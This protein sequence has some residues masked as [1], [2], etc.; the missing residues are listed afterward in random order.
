MTKTRRWIFYEKNPVTHSVT[1]SG[2]EKHAESLRFY[3]R[4]AFRGLE[5][6]GFQHKVIPDGRICI[7]SKPI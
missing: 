4:G 2:G 3:F 5:G 7:S 6:E 1:L